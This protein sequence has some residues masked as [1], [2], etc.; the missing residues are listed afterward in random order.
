MATDLNLTGRRLSI[1]P[2]GTVDLWLI[3]LASDADT[4]SAMWPALD[5]AEKARADRLA[6]PTLRRRFVAGHTNVRAILA[7][8]L[9][10]TP[11]TVPFVRDRGGKPHVSGDPLA[12]NVS[13]SDELTVCAVASGGRLGVDIERVRFVADA[14]GLADRFFSRGESDEIRRRPAD[15]RH[16]AFLDTWTRKEAFV[17]A[18]GE[19]LSRPLDSF[20]VTTPSAGWWMRACAPA[21]GYV[22]SVAHDRPIAVVACRHPSAIIRPDSREWVAAAHRTQPDRRRRGGDLHGQP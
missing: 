6:T 3:D 22:G 1:P 8:Y 16:R 15:A 12:F 14:E 10:L 4:L 21:P 17:K 18:T 5:A 19:G 2:D 11:A 9:G 20:D 7:W 13:H